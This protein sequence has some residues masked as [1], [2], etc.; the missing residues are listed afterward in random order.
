MSHRWKNPWLGILMLGGLISGGPAAH[1]ALPPDLALVPAD[2]AG[3]VHVRAADLW[4]A[5]PLAEV[6][7]MIELAGPQALKVFDEQFVPHP[8]T[9]E[10]LTVVFP[11]PDAFGRIAPSGQPVGMSALMI[12]HTAKPYDKAGLVKSLMP[13]AREK[14]FQGRSYLLD[15]RNW[16]GLYL[17]DD[18][19]LVYGAEDAVWFMLERV[20]RNQTSGPLQAGL[21]GAAGKHHV[22]VGLNP[23]ALSRELALPPNLQPLIEAQLALATFDL[24]TDVQL[25][26]EL[27]YTDGAKAKAGAQATE[28]ALELLRQVGLGTA[29]KQLQVELKQ[30]REWFAIERGPDGK[31]LPAPDDK[32]PTK[33]DR[34]PEKVMLLIAL[35]QMTHLDGE[36]KKL[37][38]EQQGTSV[39]VPYRRPLA[40][41]TGLLVM[42]STIPFLGHQASGTFSYVGEKVFSNAGGEDFADDKAKE[43]LGKIAEALDKYHAKNGRFPPAAIYGADGEPLLS[44]RVLLLPYLGEDNLFK[45]FRLDEPWDSPS[46]KPLLTKMPKVF[47]PEYHQYNPVWKSPVQVIT[48]PGTI[49]DGP[50]GLRKEDVT[51]GPENTL[52][53]IYGPNNMQDWPH[54]TRPAD[55]KYDPM[56]PVP[57][58]GHRGGLLHVIT[59]DGKFHLLKSD[60]PQETLRGLIT[61][62]GGEKVKL[63]E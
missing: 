58:R 25:G 19:T 10:R 49:F 61:R 54:W 48:G 1:A 62:N 57:N 63:P 56:K 9:V 13:T 23:A 55:L 39:R 33:L 5:E 53:L 7:K 41:T 50:K 14:K 47:Q 29:I 28:A 16:A 59:A 27:Q 22:V 38:V 31:P 60:T 15:D 36:L 51:D 37:T 43:N 34:L 21:E 4:N 20:A 30:R 3:F 52:L 6:R 11:T 18:R 17:A 44:W 42:G 45:Q 32:E 35:G 8:S 46:N 12:V 2:A 24:G 40:Q 26:L